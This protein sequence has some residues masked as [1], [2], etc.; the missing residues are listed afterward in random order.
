M[1]HATGYLTVDAINGAIDLLV[2]AHP[3]TCAKI[4]IGRSAERR[5]IHILKLG[6]GTR[7]VL[8]I[9]GMHAREFVNPDLL[10][11]LAAHLA[12]AYDAGTGLT[13]T[14]G[15]T[16]VTRSDTMVRLLVENL[17]IYF[18]PVANPDG[19]VHAFS[20]EASRWWRKTRNRNPGSTCRGRRPQPPLRPAVVER[21]RLVHRPLPVQLRHDRRR[22]RRW[23]LQG[24]QPD[25][26]ARSQG[27]RVVPRRPPQRALPR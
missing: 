8:L 9:G 2:A 20:S 23:R 7:G 25:K 15:A 4:N 11:T 22:L 27:D 21:Y 5:D 6:Q 13:Y 19:R 16:T 26:P 1:S 24:Q 10:M 18:L 14:H 12:A 17:A 3:A